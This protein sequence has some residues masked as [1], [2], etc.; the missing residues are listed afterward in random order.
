MYGKWNDKFW[1]ERLLEEDSASRLL[2]SSEKSSII[3]Q[4]MQEAQIQ[5]QRLK[6]LFGEQQADIYIKRLGYQIEEEEPELMPSFLY[7]GITEPDRR[8]VRLNQTVIRLLRAY[9][10]GHVPAGSG[11][12]ER[13]MDIILFHEL[14]HVIEESTAGIYTRNVKVP[15][16]ILGLFPWSRRIEAASEIGAIH[17]SKLMAEADFPP[18]LYTQYL[19]AATNQYTDVDDEYGVDKE[20][21]RE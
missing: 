13:M 4:C 18:Y 10:E 14:F 16:R 12:R 3:K 21:R 2:N 6:K 7:M 19:L 15:C 8:T 9:L 5:K 11:Q 17:F 20:T 1:Y